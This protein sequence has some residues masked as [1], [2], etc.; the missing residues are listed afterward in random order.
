[1]K[2]PIKQDTSLRP[3]YFLYTSLIVG[4]MAVTALWKPTL[5]TGTI[6]A[7]SNF[8]YQ[9]FDWLIMWLPLLAFG[10]GL[11]VALPG[12]FGNIRLGG[13]DA[14]PEYSFISW[15]NM[16]FTA[17]IGVGI[18]FFGPIEA[19]WHYFQSPI[20]EQAAGLPEYQKVGNA[21]GL[22]LHVWGIPAW[23]LYMLAGLVMA[24]F[25]YQHK[26]ECSPAAPIEF[27]FKR[28]KWA[29]PLGKLIAGAAVVSI[30]FSVSSSIA[31]AVSQ[32]ASG[33]SIITG[34]GAASILEKTVLLTVMIAICLFAT[35]LPIRKGMKVLGDTTVALSVLLLVFVFLTGPTHYFV[36]VITVTVGHIITQTIGHSFELY[37]FQPRDWIVWYPMAYWVWWV[38]WAPFVGVFLA[39]I[40]KGRTLREFVLASVLVPSGFILVWFCTFSGFSLLDTVEGSGVL[41]EIANKGD[42]EGTFYHLLNML[43]AAFATKPLTVVLFLGF[44][45]TTVVSAAIS[46]GVMT[47]TDGRSENKRR[48][49]VW[50]VF[51]GMI[52]Y[53][54]VFTGKIDG[55]KAVGSF[56]GFPFVFVFY[57]W[58]AALW[59]QLRRDTAAKQGGA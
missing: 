41:A 40:S 20:G 6:V 33:I 3:N 50:C 11:A 30:A 56:A 28:K 22:A 27:A 24:Y 35:V 8:F 23:S 32:I 9:K 4:L 12:K 58:M 53:A 15:M 31:M 26:T 34:R 5:L 18:V 10:F 46:L 57:L 25:L 47:S 59:R 51:M 54:V 14:K 19:L 1:M 29:A 16:L 49:I 55:I 38:T 45:I 17:G 7:V 43:P 52:S 13:Q 39:Q 48:A 36:S 42:Y 37:L 44:V 21:M 2:T